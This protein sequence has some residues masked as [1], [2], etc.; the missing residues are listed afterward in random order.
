[1]ACPSGKDEHYNDFS[2]D[3]RK[4]AAE[5]NI[6]IAAAIEITSRCNLSCCHCF[7]RSNGHGD[8]LNT[9][10][11]KR[12]IDQAVEE[13]LLW[14]CITGG[15]PLVREDFLE[16]YE[17]AKTKGVL[18][19]LFTNGTALTGPIVE[20]LAEYPPFLVEITLYGASAHTY[21]AITGN[22]EGFAKTLKGVESLI[23][24]GIN[25]KL[26]SMILRQNRRDIW[27]M[28]AIAEQMGV[29][30]SFDA[31]V[32]PQ[33][34]EVEW[35]EDLR[36]SPEEVIALDLM[37][38]GKRN[39]WM[40][41][42]R[43]H[44][45][46]PKD[47]SRLFDC[48]VGGTDFYVDAQGFLRTCALYRGLGYDLGKA[49]FKEAWKRLLKDVKDKRRTKPGLCADCSLHAFCGICPAWSR[50]EEKDEEARVDYLCEVGQLR[51]EA[52]GYMAHAKKLRSDLLSH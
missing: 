7:V 31:M 38:D 51:G 22:A 36:L 8:S 23:S 15:E 46:P 30:F 24:N 25:V 35:S 29:P 17:H 13:G 49:P 18:V 43:D 19:T 16:I 28:K 20:R 39:A 42:A 3:L 11:W 44:L 34:G 5:K 37:D 12:I 50:L 47:S 2:Y 9:G 21:G 14:L 26:K 52:F 27:E 33:I 10:Q 6:P 40:D 4:K 32:H 45:G 1:M 41:V 48:G